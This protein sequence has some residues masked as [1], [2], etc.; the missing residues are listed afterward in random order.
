MRDRWTG[1]ATYWRSL[2]L[3]VEHVSPLKMASLRSKFAD[4]CNTLEL[5]A[6]FALNWSPKLAIES[7]VFFVGLFQPDAD[8]TRDSLL[9]KL[10][11][12]SHT[13][14]LRYLNRA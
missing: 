3:F 12:V 9:V 5:E 7:A 6:A 2:N 11:C 10:F 4:F 13:C 14:T 1:W 8:V